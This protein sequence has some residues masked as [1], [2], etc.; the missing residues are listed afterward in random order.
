MSAELD[1]DS[2]LCRI[3]GSGQ[4]G[5]GITRTIKEGEIVQLCAKAKE[6][7]MSQGSMLEAMPPI[8]ICGDVHGQFSDVLRIFDRTGFP[9]SVNYMFLGDYVD[10]GEQSL[11][12]ICL[13]FCYKIKYPENFLLI[14]GNHECAAI[15]RVYGFYDE[16][17]RRY[18][19]LRLWQYFQDVFNA[20]PLC[21]LVGGRIL[22]M[23][24]GLSPRLKTLDQLRQLFRPI[25]PPNPSLHVDLLWADPD[26]Y[27]TGFL[28]SNRGL[29]YVFGPDVVK[30]TCQRLDID[31][32][33]RAHQVVQDGYEFCAN[34]RMVTIFSAPNYCKQFN[35]N[36]AVM[37]VDELLICSF[38]VM[39]PVYRPKAQMS[40]ELEQKRKARAQALSAEQAR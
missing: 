37:C 26:N 27:I 7:F 30:A 6:V 25:D 18:Q 19:S 2:M 24:G 39:K 11:E 22:C 23:H 15:N 9:P 4:T 31:L 12:T 5:Y 3:L 32:V 28:P 13:F 35:N 1:V 10:R 17:N 20:M 33:V 8:K 16:C 38:E 34:R 14:R 36:A 40:R 21:G 29:S